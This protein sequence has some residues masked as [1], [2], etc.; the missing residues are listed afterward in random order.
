MQ[1][2]TAASFKTEAIPIKLSDTE[3]TNVDVLLDPLTYKVVYIKGG[4]LVR[5]A[6]ALKDNNNAARSA[7]TDLASKP[8]LIQVPIAF[9]PLPTAPHRSPPLPIAFPPLPIAPHRS[10]SLYFF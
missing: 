3:T 9:P 7:L 10:P 6:C 4:T 8:S 1:M 2:L 5:A